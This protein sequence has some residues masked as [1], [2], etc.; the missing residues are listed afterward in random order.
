[1]NKRNFRRGILVG[2]AGGMATMLAACSP[3]ASDPAD[4]KGQTIK[5]MVSSG[6]QQFNPVW[7]T[8][9]AKWEAETGINVELDKVDT[10]DI[11][12][13]FLRDVTVGGCTV[14]NVEMLDGGTA[15]AATHMADLGQFLEADGSSVDELLKDQVPFAQE[16]YSFDGKLAYYPFYSGAK[17]VAYRKSWFADPENQTAFASEYGYELPQPPTT[18]Q[19]VKDVA[20]FFSTDTTKGIVF[21]GSGDPG[22]TTLSDLIFRNGVDGYQDSQGNALWGPEHKDNQMK[23]AEAADYLTS[24]ITD[25][26]TPDSIAAMQSADTVSTFLGG[27]TAM[28]YDHIYLFWDQMLEAQGDLGDIGSF[29]FP[30]FEEGEGG[31]SFYWGRGIPEC[32]KHKEASWEFT[33][34]IM[35]PEIQKLALSEGSGVYVPTNTE[36]L[37][38]SVEQNLIPQGVADSV[39]HAKAYKVTALT[40]QIRQSIDISLV[41]KLIGG[42]L[43]P[44]EYAEESG[45]QMQDAAEEAGLVD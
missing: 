37:D 5:V 20:S 14:D 6:H 9:L 28:L 15:A 45:K 4:L 1:M 8:E 18:P 13:K 42:Q 26:N 41:E 7:E 25:G 16:A 29:E 32:S 27:N 30:S 24:F 21:S 19:Q 17:G 31:I 34:W 3:G 2:V 43:S 36:L 39:K 44:E 38:W 12:S 23:V 40:N 22:E 10:T 35:S 33:K 11:S